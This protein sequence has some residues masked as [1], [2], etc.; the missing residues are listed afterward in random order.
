MSW[1]DSFKI[2][3]TKTTMQVEFF[4]HDYARFDG[5]INGVG[6]I[7]QGSSKLPNLQE[8]IWVFV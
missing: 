5:L 4:T 7:F 2:L 8:F 6:G 1:M 3:N